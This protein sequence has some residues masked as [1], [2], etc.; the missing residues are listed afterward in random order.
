VRELLR[1]RGRAAHGLVAAIVVVAASVATGAKDRDSSAPPTIKITSP[2]GRSGLPGT[3]R[4]VARIDAPGSATGISVAFAIDGKPLS[5]DSDG[6]PY[7]AAWVDDNP[8]ET[9]EITAEATIAEGVTIRDAVTLKPLEITEAADVSSVG[10]EATVVDASGRFV[11]DLSAEDFALQED[12]IAE[13][14]DFFRQQ[15][16]P[17]LFTLLVDSSH[18]MSIRAEAVRSA[19][20]RFLNSIAADDQVIVA[21]FSRGINAITGPTTDHAT[22][23]QAIGAI[24]P[25]GGTAILDALREAV[26][27]LTALPGRRAV[28]L[29]TDGYD[30]HSQSQIDAALKTLNG[31]N[32][33][34][35]VIGFGGIAGISLNGEDLLKTVAA[36]TGGRA[37]FPRDEPQLAKAYETIAS[38]VQ[39]RYFLTYTPH[40]Q[41]RDGTWRKISV[42]ALKPGLKVRARAGYNAPK[43]PPV[44]PVI[45]F[46]AVGASQEP[47]WVTLDDL[48][49]SEDGVEQK[50]ETFEE[51]VDP[52][53]VVLTLDSSGSMK[54]SATQAQAAA[55]DFVNALRPE[56]RIA[57]I[58][59]ADRSLVV[60][61]A[62]D[63]RDETVKAIDGYVASGGTALNDALVDS[64]TQVSKI[65][66]RRAIVVVTDGRDENAAS[67][68]PGS[69]QS[70]N[71]VVRQL[72]QTEATIY[73][74]GLG[75]NVDRSRL[76]QLAEKTGGRA[77]F[78]VDVTTLASSYRKIVDELRRRY[79]IGYEST[80][81][82][83]DGR[84]RKLD[85]RTREGSVTVRSRG[86]YFAPPADAVVSR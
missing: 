60:H 71:D 43:A 69:A 30:E 78:P 26:D 29:I 12:G 37:W 52:V 36:E 9:R 65:E 61:G 34:V 50:V 62:T 80:N 70:W 11:S 68:G 8:F 64:L 82:S 57:M 53:T 42:N 17:A 81:P 75:A 28:V 16:D 2:L 15:R 6:A 56:D 45:E 7:E 84:W 41:R 3:I 47:A 33:P 79:V 5:T 19:A 76:E 32:V 10:V 63:K 83:R 66:G 46:T 18:S 24:R 39:H 77:F 86:G 25:A 20:R 22:V 13:K 67:N 59:F 54:K 74:I 4:I 48:V 1:R 85:I 21:P 51:A 35:Y 40:N 27:H 14:I 55:R 49:V 31:G 44:R 38:E 58:S 73:A 72:D 23:L